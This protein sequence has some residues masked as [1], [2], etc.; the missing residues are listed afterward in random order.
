[1]LSLLLA[2]LICPGRLTAQASVVVVVRHAEKVVESGP[3]PAL[4]PVGRDRAEA[5]AR[6]L[7]DA[8]ITH[9]MVSEF[10]RTTETAA[11]LLQRDQLSAHTVPVGRA[12]IYAHARAVAA[13]VDS[14]P[15]GSAVLIVGHSNTV[16]A[17]IAALGGPSMPDLADD[18]YASLFVL[19]RSPGLP[20]R[21][22]RT[23][24]G[25][26]PVPLPR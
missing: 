3:D 4:S 17:I 15:S 14:L 22:L 12:G 5:L 8:H 18:E 1:M 21:L 13:A 19:T 7:I 9:V 6:V 25:E 23:T 20:V 24:F 2:A 16:P 10:R 26:G 11:P